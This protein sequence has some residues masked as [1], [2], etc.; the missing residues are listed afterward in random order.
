MDI[1][2]FLFGN[3]LK[4]HTKTKRV[5]DINSSINKVN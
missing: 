4:I 1:I 2:K 3:K 5:V